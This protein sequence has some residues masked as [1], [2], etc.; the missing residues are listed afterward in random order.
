MIGNSP[1]GTATPKCRRCLPLLLLGTW[2]VATQGQAADMATAG[3]QQV[4]EHHGGAARSGLYVVPD[5]TW[6]A[7]GHLQRDPR[8]N[9]DVAGP[10]YAQPL[11]WRSA[12]S[13]HASLL[14]ATEQNL[15]YALDSR[16]G[17]PAWKSTLGSPVGR[18]HLPCGNIDPLGITGTPAI[19][20]R[21][22][23][24]YLD[25]MISD[26][27]SGAPKHMIFALS[28]KDGSVLPGWPVDVEA[29]LKRSGQTFRSPVQNQRG[30]LTI[31]ADA[32]YVPYGGHFGDCGDYRGWVVSV[33]LQSPH[34]VRS[35]STRARGGGVWAPGGVSS[36]GTALYLATGNTMAAA[37]WGDG[38][39]VIR[40]GPDLTFSA[41]PRDYFAPSDW[42][43]LDATDADLG[44]TNPLLVSLPGATSLEL[45]LAFGKDGNAY[46][47]DRR[48]LG[49]IGGNVVSK[50]VSSDAIRTSPAYVLSGNEAFVAF[51]GTGVDCPHGTGG[52]LVVLKIASGSPPQLG[53]AWCAAANGRGSPVITTTDGRANPIVW[54]VGAEGSNRLRGFRADT[55][56]L[57]FAG[58][59]PAEAMS[60]VRRFQAPIVV[61]RHLYVA[62]DQRV[63][64]FMF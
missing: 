53:I 16:T 33:S 23:T 54:I 42:I 18:S 46:L 60:Q 25:A 56:A 48:N 19:D 17:V 30:A 57:V 13:D 8:F 27:A 34:T 21:T 37:R 10:V 45:M 47:L 15:V 22:Q 26:K 38:E 44:G 7:A 12:A 49:G 32:V 43:R 64:A 62:A 9:A 63:Y 55:G 2:A 5:L 20:E 61:G 51:Q 36:D 4:L 58:G 40:L 41:Q 6:E 31:A 52:D 50:R 39:A 24:V 1:A 29:A 59:G 28:L 11:Y 3:T 14:V 35:W